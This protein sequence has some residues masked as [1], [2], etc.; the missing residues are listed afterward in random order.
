MQ[1]HEYRRVDIVKAKTLT[2]SVINQLKEFV[3]PP[4]E[5]GFLRPTAKLA[6]NALRL[7]YIDMAK[8]LIEGVLPCERRTRALGCLVR[9]W[10]NAR[11]AFF[12]P[13]FNKLMN[14]DVVKDK[15]DLDEV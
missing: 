7:E 12:T 11:M 3:F 8:K 9:S 2:Y 15:F 14:E 1:G 5:L 13:E 6:H 4:R 10:E